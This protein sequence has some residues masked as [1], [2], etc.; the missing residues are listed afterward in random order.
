MNRI[1]IFLLFA[2]SVV[3]TQVNAFAATTVTIPNP[4]TAATTT[5][6]KPW[7]SRVAVTGATGRTGRYVV[8]ELI[9]RGI[10]VVA[11]VRDKVKAEEAF[12]CYISQKEDDNR[13]DNVPTVTIME[14]DLT[15]KDQIWTSLSGCDATIWCATGFSEVPTPAAVQAPTPSPVE[16]DPFAF[17]T[18]L[19]EFLKIPT[20]TAKPET[21]VTP[22]SPPPPKVSIDLVGVPLVAKYFENEPTPSETSSSSSSSFPNVVLLSSAGVTRTSWDDTKKARYPGSAEIPIVRLNPF[23]ILDLKAESEQSLRESGTPYCIVRPTGLNDKDWPA[24]SRP[25]LSQGDVAVGRIHRQ[26]V[27]KVLVNVLLSPEATGKTFEVMTLAGYP[28]PASLDPALKR[29]IRDDE[30]VNF[31]QDE[32]S[33]YAT[34]LTLQQMLPGEKQDSANIALGQTYEQMDQ[35]QEGRFGPRGA[36]QVEKVLLKPTL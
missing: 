11:M 29:L 36:E 17:V 14:C 32:V 31:E 7:V 28:P 23:G 3:I 19:M 15:S 12:E 35:N 16:S 2:T 21:P 13:N 1:H 33:T 24:G 26:D 5:S 9:N 4:V 18:K 20:D 6:S 10:D 25:I 34:Y 30:L 27:A 22:E 8:Q